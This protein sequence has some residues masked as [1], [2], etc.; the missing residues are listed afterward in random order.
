MNGQRSWRKGGALREGGRRIS[1]NLPLEKEQE[2]IGEGR[3][4]R[5]R[6]ATPSLLLARGALRKPRGR[7][8]APFGWRVSRGAE[9]LG[10]ARQYEVSP[11]LMPIGP[12]L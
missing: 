3:E 1:G 11:K 6:A 5:I 7:T 8:E 10:G 9:G 12:T 2:K 4:P